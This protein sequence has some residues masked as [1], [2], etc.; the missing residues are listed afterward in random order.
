MYNTYTRATGKRER[1]REGVARE[2]ELDLTS[3]HEEKPG[4]GPLGRSN[5]EG[6]DEIGGRE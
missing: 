2:R 4:E 6:Q 1:E 5:G 3:P